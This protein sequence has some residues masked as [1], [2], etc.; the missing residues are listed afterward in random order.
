M[1]QP[2]EAQSEGDRHPQ[3]PFERQ[4]QGLHGFT[5]AVGDGVGSRQE[6]ELLSGSSRCTFR[7]SM[8]AQRSSSV[9]S[10]PMTPC[11]G[12]SPAFHGR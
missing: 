8:M 10:G 7:Y 4:E 5:S 9:S 6:Q 2:Q 11:D 3:Q 1:V 12:G